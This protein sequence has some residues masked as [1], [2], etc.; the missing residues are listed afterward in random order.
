MQYQPG[1]LVGVLAKT[2]LDHNSAYDII[3]RI[4]CC[5]RQRPACKLHDI[6]HRMILR[7]FPVAMQ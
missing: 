5:P 2:L 3:F 7:Y 6:F 1:L 4:L